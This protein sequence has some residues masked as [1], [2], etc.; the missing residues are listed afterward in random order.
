M[1]RMYYVSRFS[2]ALSGQDIDRIGES[3]QRYNRQREITGFLV[4]LGDAFFQVLEGAGDEVDRL[5]HERIAP[6]ERHKDLLRLKTEPEVEERLFPDWSMKVFNLN[7]AAES[8]PFA[9]REMLSSLLE[10]HRIIAE[11]TQPS[12]LEMLEQG[13]RP[14]SVAPR[15]E[16]VTVLYSDIIGFSRFAEHVAA[17]EL[18]GLVNS[19]AEIC[20]AAVIGE[21]GQVNKLTGD[22]VLAYFPGRSP[23]SAIEA[24]LSILGEMARQRAASDATSAHR[25][26]Y[27]GVGLVH[28]MV[29]EGNVG[30]PLKR[31]FTILGNTVNLASRIESMTRDLDVRLTI[32]GSVIR[33]A[34]REY[35]FESL[36]KHL[37]KGQS[38]ELELF[39][40]RTLSR[41]DI[42]DVYRDIEAFVTQG[43]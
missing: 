14:T 20:S 26:L 38:K 9:F 33:S 21:G 5:Y 1:K 18:I 42:K 29:H 39:T 2:R 34:T 36:G 24:A 15:R 40:L 10:S 8:L 35:P 30:S 11:Y 41:L 31:D 27:G 12:L 23:D 25:H 13:I 22:G 3:A 16:R 4:C 43:P 32:D 28:G 7:N 6:D 19:H 17:E 37:L